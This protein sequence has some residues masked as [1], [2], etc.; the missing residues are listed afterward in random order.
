MK[1]RH[2]LL[3]SAL[4]VSALALVAC[5]S[6]GSGDEEK[7][8]EAI[9]TSATA[10][11]PA[12][13]AKLETLA[14]SEQSSGESGKAAVEACEEEAKDPEG[15]AESVAVSEVEVD[16]SKA[17]ANAAITGGSLEGQTASIALVEEDGQWKLDQI[18]GF[19]ELDQAQLAK[20]FEEQLEQGEEVEPEVTACIVAGI[21]DA[22]KAEAEEFVLDA[23][24]QALGELAESCE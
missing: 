8:E 7:I 12:N 14:F 10:S 22:S 15:K 1:K 5:G 9:E 24:N 17:T 3:I 6:S 4:L 18:T 11:D 19:V 13:C 21:E 23:D 2:L 16:G 20:V